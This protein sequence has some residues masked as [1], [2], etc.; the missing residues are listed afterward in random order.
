MASFE[1]DKFL[2]TRRQ[3]FSGGTHLLGTAALGSLLGQR[4][5]VVNVG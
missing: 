2:A 1:D 5:L 3:F 4:G